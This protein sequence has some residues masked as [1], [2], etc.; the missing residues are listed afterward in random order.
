MLRPGAYLG[1]SL[2]C[3]PP[4]LAALAALTLLASLAAGA[5]DM[6]YEGNPCFH[7]ASQRRGVCK[8]LPYCSWAV[9]ERRSGLFPQACSFVGFLPVVCCP[10]TRA[11]DPPDLP[12]R[13]GPGQASLGAP[14]P[15]GISA[16]ALATLGVS[17]RAPTAVGVRDQQRQGG[18]GYVIPGLDIVLGDGSALAS[19]N[20]G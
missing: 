7:Q 4:Q 13:P 3:S 16:D 8:L 14:V 12:L 1:G 19:H 17:S 6:L 18:Q 9:K 15:P 20:D 10:Y 2:L 5:S 11:H